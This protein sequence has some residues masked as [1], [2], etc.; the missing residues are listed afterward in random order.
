MNHQYDYNSTHEGHDLLAPIGS[1]RA[2]RNCDFFFNCGLW[3]LLSS[4]LV[5]FPSL[6]WPP[7]VQFMPPPTWTSYHSP[8]LIFLPACLPASSVYYFLFGCW[9]LFPHGVCSLA[10]STS[11][12]WMP[13]RPSHG[14]FPTSHKW[15]LR[16]LP[17]GNGSFTWIKSST[18]WCRCLAAATSLSEIASLRDCWVFRES[19]STTAERRQY[20]LINFSL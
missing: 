15:T 6:V 1:S 16:A 7:H 3:L 9:T 4:N 11:P 12:A 5:Q 19:S 14:I 18:C 10:C 20:R 2:V 17:S 13:S 8:N